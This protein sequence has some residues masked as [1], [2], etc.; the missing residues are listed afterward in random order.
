MTLTVQRD[1]AATS[2]PGMVEWTMSRLPAHGGPVIACP[3]VHTGG[4][5]ARI[6]EHWAPNGERE[7]CGRHE[8]VMGAAVRPSHG[9]EA[10]PASGLNGP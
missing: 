6:V 4:R 10:A 8:P 5:R 9:Y 3:T 7:A 1:P 2:V